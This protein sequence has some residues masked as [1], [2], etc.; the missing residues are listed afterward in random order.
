[1]LINHFLKKYAVDNKTFSKDAITI[2]QNY[3]WKGNIR[4]LENIIERV[5][6]LSNEDV[7]GVASLP[8]EIRSNTDTETVP[9]SGGID[10]DKLMEDTE[11]AYLLKALEETNGVKTEAAKLL[12]LTF[13][14]F[15]HKLKKYGID[16]KRI[17]D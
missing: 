4:E 6:L 13:R 11:K 7:I 12:K 9:V 14:S 5:L 17:T 3:Y 10:F 16:K 8:E 2:L 1:L 15:R